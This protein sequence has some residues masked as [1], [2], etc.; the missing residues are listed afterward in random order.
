[1]R[2]NKCKKTS[3]RDVEG[4]RHQPYQIVMN[5]RISQL[6]SAKDLALRYSVSA[7][8]VRKWARTS[9]LPVVRL[10]CRCIRFDIENCDEIIL[11]RS[12]IATR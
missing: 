2:A 11:K 1:M 12:R 8:T 9:L 5:N 7:K 3:N 10:N 4:Q 6:V